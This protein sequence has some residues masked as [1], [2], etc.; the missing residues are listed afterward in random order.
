M[1]YIPANLNVS[2]PLKQRE[3]AQLGGSLNSLTKLPGHVLGAIEAVGDCMTSQHDIDQVLAT[4]A[5]GS[6]EAAG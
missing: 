3:E 1:Q 2:K 4:V 5:V 6:Y